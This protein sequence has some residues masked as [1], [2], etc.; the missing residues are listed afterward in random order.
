MEKCQFKFTKRMP[1]SAWIKFFL[2]SMSMYIQ[3]WTFP[4]FWYRYA[5]YKIMKRWRCNL[6]WSI[7]FIYTNVF[8]LCYAHF[9]PGPWS[10]SCNGWTVAD[11]H[12]SPYSDQPEYSIVYCTPLHIPVKSLPI[13][14]TYADCLPDT[15]S[16]LCPVLHKQVKKS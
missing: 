3:W 15:L 1:H 7:H 13:S 5:D 14:P 8:A 6:W 4:T 11:I 9:C 10:P 12:V 2:C 16:A